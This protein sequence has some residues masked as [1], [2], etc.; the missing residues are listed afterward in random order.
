MGWYDAFKGH[1]ERV[2]INGMESA[3][4]S[5]AKNLGDA[6][7]DI[8]KEMQDYSSNKDKSKLLALQTQN[9]QS[10]IEDNL[11][12]QNQKKIEDAWKNINLEETYFKKQDDKA[13][14]KIDKDFNKYGALVNG[15]ENL[16][17]LKD[18]YNNGGAFDNVS[19]DAINALNTRIDNETKLEQDKSSEVAKLNSAK[20]DAQNKIALLKKEAEIAGLKKDKNK[21]FSLANQSSVAKMY[22]DEFY[23]KDIDD[24]KILKEG[25]TQSEADAAKKYIDAYMV[26]DGSDRNYPKASSEAK[27]FWLQSD[28][29]ANEQAQLKE[30]AR[31]S[32]I[33]KINTKL[34]A[35]KSKVFSKDNELILQ[36]TNE[37]RNLKGESTPAEPKELNSYKDLKI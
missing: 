29:F 11:Y 35:E 12:N 14:Q 25:V 15:S 21:P 23:K 36:Y 30:K 19:V 1:T 17:T 33:D 5:G 4:G 6:F 9:E 3:S 7:K 37:L 13:Q 16:Q 26:A 2:N 31:L 32:E 28:E 22:S 34:E 8:G 18:N 24:N 10:K 27:E 20:K